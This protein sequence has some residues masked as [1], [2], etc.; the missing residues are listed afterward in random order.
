[1]SGFTYDVIIIGGGVAGCAVA[2]EL[3]EG[4]LRALQIE[5]WDIRHEFTFLWRAGSVFETQYRRLY[6]Q[7]CCDREDNNEHDRICDP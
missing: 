7:L 2:R 3:A 4:R 5:N 6:E 1:M